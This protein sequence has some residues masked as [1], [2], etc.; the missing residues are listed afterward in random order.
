MHPSHKPNA[1][2]PIS[3]LSTAVM[4]SL[5]I[6]QYPYAQRQWF[7]SRSKTHRIG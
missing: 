6:M 5:P 3:S 7:A 2:P 1:Q 4:A